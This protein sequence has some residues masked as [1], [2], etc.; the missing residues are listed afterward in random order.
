MTKMEYGWGRY[1]E[2]E[3]IYSLFLTLQQQVDWLWNYQPAV[4][5]QRKKKTF[6]TRLGI[7]VSR[8]AMEA[9]A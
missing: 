9:I 3:I 2:Q 1:D 4:W 6:H 5:K 7:K 8:E